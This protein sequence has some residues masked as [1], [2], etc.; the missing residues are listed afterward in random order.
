MTGVVHARRARRDVTDGAE[1]PRLGR[2][3]DW[4]AEDADHETLRDAE[5]LEEFVEF[6]MLP[7]EGIAGAGIASDP[8][9]RERLRSRLWRM[10]VLARLRTGDGLH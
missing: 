8:A 10:H 5:L 2:P 9:F 1:G 6:V 7:D 3:G 4:C